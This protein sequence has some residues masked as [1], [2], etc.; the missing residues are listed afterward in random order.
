MAHE[1]TIAAIATAPGEGGIG[2]I[3]LSGPQ[4][5]AA[6]QQ[7]SPDFPHNP[8]PRKAYLRTIQINHNSDL[9]DQAVLTYFKTPAS[10]TGEDVVEISCHG[11]PLLLQKLLQE[12]LKIPDV[13]LARPG[14]FTRQ[15]FTA[16]KLDLAQ[17]A[18]VGNLIAARSE[19][20]L[21][22]SS[23][24]LSGELSK[25]IEQLREKVV[26]IRCLLEA[27]LDFND[28]DS[29]QELD[30][31]Q[32]A[33]QLREVN[34]KL[35][36]LI[37]QGE[38]G[39]LITSGCQLAI[40]GPPNV[41]KSS[42]FNLLLK[43]DRAIVT[44]QPGTTR[45]ILREDISLQGIPITLHDTAGIH[46]AAEEIEAHGVERS[47]AALE[48][49]DAAIFLLDSRYPPGQNEQQ[50]NQLIQQARTPTVVVLNKID[51]EDQISDSTVEKKLARP[52]DCRISV[53][54]R[55]G[56]DKLEKQIVQKLWSGE[57]TLD[58][59]L[60]TRAEQIELLKSGRAHL[61]AALTKLDCQDELTLIAEDLRLCTTEISK[62]I[63][64]ISTEDILDRIFS[65]FCIGK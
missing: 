40:V 3:R 20:A 9:T 7:I 2:V 35:T 26:T 21:R 17:A 62:I 34:A 57:V 12:L 52:V 47:E 32:L 33:E 23:R 45:D 48:T 65:D 1:E 36:G 18:A 44:A 27:S 10:Y 51:L 54:Q 38:L 28:E 56:I 50:I 15:A 6:V 8:E 60:V 13:R 58:N 16:G 31:D 30:L 53:K 5:L 22:A 41:G 64:E 39:E 37:D 42:L 29:V 19:A 43:K 59:P 55:M 46:E 25:L 14:E 49:A 63:G 4:S 24:Q 11:S 61:K